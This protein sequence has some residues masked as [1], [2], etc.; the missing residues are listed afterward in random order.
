MRPLP[1]KENL[2]ICFAHVAYRMAERFALRATGIRHFEVR[3]LDELTARLGEFDVLSVSMLWR[4]EFIAR[5]PRL[6]FIQSIS[7]GTDQYARDALAAAGIRLASAQG[8]NAEAVAQHAMALILALTRQLHLARDN[9]A[10]RHWRGMISDLSQ[11][12]DELT[13]KTLLIVGLGRIGARLATMARAF[14]MRTIATKRDASAGADAA[15]AVF[16][17]ERLL[18]LLPQADAVALTCPLT[19]ETERLINAQALAAMKPSAVLIN[20]A[21][22]KVVD[23]PAL[24][25]AL[26]ARRIAAA[27]IDCTVDEPLPAASPLWALDNAL[28]TP[29]TAGETRRYEDNV[30]DLLVENLDRIWRG[31]SQLRNHIV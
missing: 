17:Q 22:G 14:G 16:P 5:A 8:V 28:I 21:R 13:G 15:D 4:N 19:P 27:G 12:E 20:V 9:Q 18:E 29:H 31:E 30:I 7:A 6:A 3:S 11:R 26:A 10:K 24:V 23:E 25:E 2:T 1:S